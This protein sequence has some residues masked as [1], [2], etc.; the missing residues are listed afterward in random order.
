M[1]YVKKYSVSLGALLVV[2]LT[3]VVV[4]HLISLNDSNFNPFDLG[5]VSLGNQEVLIQV[6]DKDIT[7]DASSFN[8]G[9]AEAIGAIRIEQLLAE[10]R[11]LLPPDQSADFY[12]RI[13]NGNV[14]PIKRIL[15]VTTWRS[16]STFLGELIS[17]S[18][19][20]FYSYEPMYYFERHNGSKAEL[21]RSLSQCQF[22]T[23]YL[24][25]MNGLVEGS[26]N[27]MVMNHR[28]WNSCQHNQSLCIQ[29]EFVGQLCS[30]FPVH[31]MKT[32]RLRVKKLSSLLSDHQLTK[33]W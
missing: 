32:V 26:Q 2:V 21:I 29:P 19:G 3:F 13:S 17:S 20:V 24:R 12:T 6:K 22:P 7:T 1:K 15:I 8:F 9:I 10:H 31:L 30:F 25:D 16:G 33:E 27:F 23:E 18:P 14:P 5:P 4:I 28:V 11:I